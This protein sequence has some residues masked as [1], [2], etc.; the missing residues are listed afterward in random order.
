MA[1]AP[2]GRR[3]AVQERSRTRP[4]RAVPLVGTSVV[5]VGDERAAGDRDRGRGREALRAG[6]GD[7]AL[8]GAGERGDQ[9]AAAPAAAATAAEDRAE[10]RGR[11][12][13]PEAAAPARRA[14]RGARRSMR[15]SRRSRSHALRCALHAARAEQ[16]PVARRDQPPDLLAVHLTSLFEL[17]QHHA[18]LIDRLPRGLLA[19]LKSRPDVRVGQLVQLAH[20][21]RRALP[22]R[23]LTA[24]SARAPAS[25]RR[26]AAARAA[27]ARRGGRPAALQRGMRS[28][29]PQPARSPRCARSGRATA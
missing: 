6:A 17:E 1:G 3:R 7:R 8:T 23:E 25:A 5:V 20:Q 29:A 13:R 2:A 26:R 21:Q 18:R 24:R 9:A 14:R 27:P 10:Q 15:G 12:A 19:G 22:I 4:G 16:P 28:P 11:G